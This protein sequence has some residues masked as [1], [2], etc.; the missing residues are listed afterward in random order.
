MR[1]LL[2]ILA[3]WLAM[4]TLA[5]ASYGQDRLLGALGLGSDACP[6]D[7][8]SFLSRNWNWHYP[9]ET[10]H[11]RNGNRRLRCENGDRGHVYTRSDIFG[12]YFV[13]NR[14]YHRV[15]ENH[16]SMCAAIRAYCVG[17]AALELAT[18]EPDLTP[19]PDNP[20]DG[21]SG[22]LTPLPEN[23]NQLGSTPP[24]LDTDS[25]GASSVAVPTESWHEVS[26]LFH[27]SV[28]ILARA[29]DDHIQRSR[30]EQ[31][32]LG[33]RENEYAFERNFMSDPGMFDAVYGF[34]LTPQRPL[35]G[36]LV[37]GGPTP[38]GGIAN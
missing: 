5:G 28:N 24:P 13:T 30:R 4:L 34:S 16:P 3:G 35:P 33:F 37:R 12:Q 22:L 1:F 26:G 9:R 36:G 17:D 15:T 38:G 19:Q 11:I 27:E 6:Q 31:A 10:P 25:I 23:S 14:R 21:P 7:G 20:P 2:M 18:S 29:L 8:V 32:P